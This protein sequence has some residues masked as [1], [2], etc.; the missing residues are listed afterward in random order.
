MSQDRGPIGTGF[1]DNFAL[2]VLEVQ[3]TYLQ[4][5]DSADNASGADPEAMYIDS[6]IVTP[7]ST[8]DLNGLTV[9][10]RIAQIDGSI[11]GGVVQVMGGVG[12]ITLD[13]PVSANLATPGQTDEW[14]FF[15]RRGM[16]V[17][18]VADP[19]GDGT[20]PPVAPAIEWIQVEFRSPGGQ[21]LASVRIRFDRGTWSRSTTWIC[22]ATASTGSA[23][24][25]EPLARQRPVIYLL[26]VANATLDV[27]PL[28]LGS[29]RP[30][31]WRAFTAGTSGLSPPSPVNRFDW[32]CS[33]LR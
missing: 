15:G 31:C 30:V 8:L 19:G 16:A 6:L 21:L 1:V 28:V 12:E 33:D 13:V 10:A 2:G 5:I 23:F 17:T 24:P 14:T 29:A 26:T 32:I 22:P 4:L 7:G 11:V 25:P 18:I 9:Y 27:R 20:P 3:S